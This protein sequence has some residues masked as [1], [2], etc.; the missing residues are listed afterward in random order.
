MK[1]AIGKASSRH[2]GY[3]VYDV[4]AAWYLQNYPGI[5]THRDRRAAERAIAKYLKTNFD[6]LGG[7]AAPL[8]PQLPNPFI[9]A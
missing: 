1:Y 3:W 9:K 2:G 7:K 4:N 6:P 5:S 8:P